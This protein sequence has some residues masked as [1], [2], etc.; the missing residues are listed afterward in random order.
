MKSKTAKSSKA[1]AHRS[2]LGY[3]G[4]VSPR[5]GKAFVLS[6][7]LSWL[8]I[9]RFYMGRKDIGTLQLLAFAANVAV[10]IVFEDSSIVPNLTGTLF[11]V[12]LLVD[13]ILIG[14]GKARDGN[15]NPL[16][17]FGSEAP[18]GYRKVHISEKHTPAVILSGLWIPNILGVDR[19]YM[20]RVGLGILKLI[21]GIITIGFGAIIWGIVDYILI[22]RGRAR[23]GRK[24]HLITPDVTILA[25]RKTYPQSTQQPPTSRPPANGP[26]F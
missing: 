1:Q 2:D 9:G 11:S 17:I 4:Y 24:R 25:S 12:W 3:Q 7:F 19:M 6:L 20:G 16:I 10:L 13:D 8:G 18:V 21:V 26:Q 23:D 5:H 14:S 15:G 22:A